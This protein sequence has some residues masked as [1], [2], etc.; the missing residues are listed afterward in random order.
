MFFFFKLKKFSILKLVQY[1][2]EVKF[3]TLGFDYM[4]K[5]QFVD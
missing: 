5:F 4:T 3:T 1:V 2:T